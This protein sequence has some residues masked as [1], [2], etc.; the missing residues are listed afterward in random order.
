MYG[1]IS[2]SVVVLYASVYTTVVIGIVRSVVI[3]AA[4]YI[5]TTDMVVMDDEKLSAYECGFVPHTMAR[6][7]FDIRFYLVAI[8]F[9]VFD[10]ETCYIFPWVITLGEQSALGYWTMVDFVI[11]LL[12][13]YI[14]AWKIGSLEWE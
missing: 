12:V 6:M 1:G 14:Y 10:L 4:S 11:E 5:I 8:L 2:D 9:I 7:P 3:I 13:G